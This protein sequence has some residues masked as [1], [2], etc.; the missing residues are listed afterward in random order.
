VTA[1]TIHTPRG[2]IIRSRS[3]RRFVVVAEQIDAIGIRTANGHIERSSDSVATVRTFSRRQPS[4]VSTNGLGTLRTI[5]D[6][7]TG[8]IVQ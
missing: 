5:F 3:Q 8:E 6:T 7:V 2:S 4:G 1:R